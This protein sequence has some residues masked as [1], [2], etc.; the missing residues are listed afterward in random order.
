MLVDDE[1]YFR[2]ALKV[3]VSWEELGFVVCGEAKNGKDALE[4]VEELNPEIIIVDINMPVMDGLE[5]V[6]ILRDK[7]LNS[8]IIILTGHSEFNY[9]KQAVQLGVY[10]YILKPVNEEELATSLL[11]LKEVIEKETDIKIEVDRLKQQ[12]RDSLPLLKDKLLNDLLQG[13]L[14]WKEKDTVKRMEY[15]NVNIHSKF[16]RAVTVEI[17]DADNRYWS[18]EDNQIW[19][20]AVSNIACEILAEYCTFDLCY[21]KNDRICFIIGSDNED[22]PDPDTL[23]ENRLELVRTVIC[24]HLK[25][26][27]T[28]GVGN[29]KGRLSDIAASYQ[30]S[31]VALKSK[32]TLGDNRIIAY[33]L[34][35]FPEIKVNLFT[36]EH[37]SQLMMN[38]RT[39]DDK[40]V[41]KL[42]IQ[43]FTEIRRRNIHH[44][45]IALLCI[46][47][48]STCMEFILEVGLS[49][50]DMFPGSKLNIIEDIQKKRSIAEMESWVEMIFGHTLEAVKTTKSSKA[51][52]QIEEVKKYIAENY[53]KNE[54][55]VDE[56][57][58]KLFVNYAHLCFI[59]KRD[60]G[61]T[62]NEYLTR[63]RINMA[64]ELLDAGNTLVLDVAERVGYADANYFGKCFKKYYGLAPSKY[65]LNIRR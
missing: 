54:L 18:D 36:V 41:Q 48:V 61:M 64:K 25:F 52:K 38:M 14:I 12:V 49:L 15:F 2:E 6:Q 46:E 55:S 42:L 51:S 20:Y 39:G 30:E 33:N 5:F 58:R 16:Y 17:D 7:G 63:F 62:I 19:K 11:E 23:L 24:K 9:A 1:Y 22:G 13:N 56:I 47:M 60:A 34:V 27:V 26:T 8:K 43:I 65:I 45:I 35:A 28:I 40:E 57:A 10:N 4:K 31:V 21:D 50:K 29:K 59:F 37:R 3:S 32:L 44:E 53:Y